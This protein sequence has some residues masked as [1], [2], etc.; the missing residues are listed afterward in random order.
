[1]TA[2]L[3]PHAEFEARRQER[4]EREIARDLLRLDS[5][6]QFSLVVDG[7][8]GVAPTAPQLELFGPATPN[9][10]ARYRAWVV[11]AFERLLGLP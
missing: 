6:A 4:I 3:I 10:D 5:N 9:D 11:R 8:F 1:M 7:W 2:L